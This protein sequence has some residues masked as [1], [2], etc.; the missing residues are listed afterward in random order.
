MQRSNIFGS[1]DIP[2]LWW[3]PSFQSGTK[4]IC[5]G[6]T[7]CQNPSC[8]VKDL[9]NAVERHL[10]LVF[11]QGGLLS[12]AD[13]PISCAALCLIH[14]ALSDGG[15][16]R[17]HPVDA[18]EAVQANRAVH[19]PSYPARPQFQRGCD[20]SQNNCRSS[21]QSD[22]P[23]HKA[24]AGPVGNDQITPICPFFIAP[25]SGGDTLAVANHC[26]V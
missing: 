7:I 4:Q 17:W 25:A 19:P 3:I 12:R 26:L 18:G 24:M 10:R 14:A 9:L 1:F 11:F 5:A 13:E 22:R 20:D 21:D 16:H 15:V 8:F 23:K 2:Q 6:S